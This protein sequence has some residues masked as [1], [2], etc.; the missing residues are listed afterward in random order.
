VTITLSHFSAAVVFAFFTSI[1]FGITQKSAP[2]E[3]FRYFLYCFAMFVGGL[4]VAGWLMW[5]IRR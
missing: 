5:L 3:Q 2:M 4:F 1:V